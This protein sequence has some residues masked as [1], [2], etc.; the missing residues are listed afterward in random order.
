[1]DCPD[2]PSDI[3]SLSLIVNGVLDEVGVFR[4]M[5]DLWKETYTTLELL[6]TIPFTPKQSTNI[7]GSKIEGTATFGM[8]SDTD[9]V[10]INQ[11]YPVVLS[12][13]DATYQKCLLLVEDDHTPPGY[14]KLQLVQNGVPLYR[15][16]SHWRYAASFLDNTNFST[17]IDIENR[18]INA[19]RPTEFVIGDC[20]R[21]GPAISTGRL[22]YVVAFNC[23]AIACS[24]AGWFSRPRLF[25][26]PPSN[27]LERCKALGCLF[28]P[29]GHPTSE[30]NDLQ[31]RISLS[32]QERLLV[33]NF[34][35]VQ[36]KCYVLL[37][38]AK[39]EFLRYFLGKEVLSSYH[40]KTCLFHLIENT[41]GEFWVPENLLTCFVTS[42]KLLQ[43]WA[44]SGVCPN[45]FINAENMFHGK[46][47][48]E[49]KQNLVWALQY[50][51]TADCK[52][53]SEIQTEDIGQRLG[54]SLFIPMGKRQQ[55]T[56]INEADMCAL[57]II[58]FLRIPRCRNEILN[59]CYMSRER[60]TSNLF[61]TVRSLRNTYT[62]T[63]HTEAETQTAVSLV[64]PYLELSLLSSLVATASHEHQS[65]DRVWRLL[66]SKRWYELSTLSDSYSSRLKQASL[67][68]SLGFYHASLHVLLQL[69]DI[70]SF[71]YC[72]CYNNILH[73][74]PEIIF[75]TIKPR[76]HVITRDH[77]LNQVLTPCVVFLPTEAHVTPVAI[78]TEMIRSRGMPPGSRDERRYFWY[79]WAIVD[80]QFLLHFLLYLNHKKLKMGIHAA[81][82]VE[83]M[84]SVIASKTV[85]HTE[86]CLNLLGW[87]YK[88]E[89]ST[90]RALDCFQM[91][92]ALQPEHNAAV[93]HI[94]DIN[95]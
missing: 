1:M 45:Y 14:A 61:Q 89:S 70:S 62:I 78:C 5:R 57:Y 33:T 21:H 71:S 72:S 18:I 59:K 23:H 54:V 86:T 48:G 47:Y 95:I 60:V 79:D 58:A 83:N 94:K 32:D 52:F 16:E 87:V 55:D 73:T 40:C 90:D 81:A 68:H 37:K 29:V 92:L 80:G 25:N 69:T 24:A 88:E 82:D 30:E 63:K 41:P 11:A 4:E 44:N 75:E 76:L 84:Q 35:S 43:L 22:D 67:M 51:L 27:L 20:Q 28:V 49:I 66:S 42:L 77:I 15:C 19:Y 17:C 53:L 26:W 9:M 64:L 38:I 91:S 31:W 93:W 34:N 13:S 7:Y 6:E 50:I 12:C 3:K 85:S 39:K 8:N 56:T 65:E 46:V 2:I 74:A 36:L 10:I